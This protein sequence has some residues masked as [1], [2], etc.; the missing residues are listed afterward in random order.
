MAAALALVRLEALAARFPSELS[1]GQQQR[2]SLARALV[3][4]PRLLLL[5]E[6]LSN[7]DARLRDEMRLE[8][9]ELQRRLGI[10]TVL[11]THDIQEAFALSDRIA[12]MRGGRIEQVGRPAEIYDRPA[13]RFVANFV[14][15]VTE[16]AVRAVEQVDGRA[17]AVLE[18]GLSVWLA[19]A[20]TGR[21][22]LLRPEAVQLRVAEGQTDNHYRGRVEDVIYLG[23]DT[24]CRVRV[25]GQVLMA[26]LPSIA[27]I[28]L[29]QGDEIAVGWNA[30]DAVVTDAG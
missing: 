23:A 2:V 8:I 12:V 11:V 1:G 26:T 24:E 22:L 10:T 6:P 4:R 15:P 9:R 13:S 30:R 14:G 19:G 16:L 5:D 21:L 17:R 20:E 7:L 18:D 27:A 28:G 29:R 3:V 25:G